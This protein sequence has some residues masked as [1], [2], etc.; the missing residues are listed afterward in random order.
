MR[1]GD[2]LKR[3]FATMY[4]YNR[5]LEAEQGLDILGDLLSQLCGSATKHFEDETIAA[6][7]LSFSGSACRGEHA[8]MDLLQKTKLATY[9]CKWIHE[10]LFY[11]IRDTHYKADEYLNIVNR[12]I[13]GFARIIECE[14][15][16]ARKPSHTLTQQ[17][18]RH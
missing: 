5:F 16:F 11:L 1:S 3:A 14:S 15:P 13:L 8:T 7:A 10:L 4:G 2:E 18:K 12:S 17:Q 9:T 6:W